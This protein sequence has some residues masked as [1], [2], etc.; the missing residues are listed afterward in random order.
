MNYGKNYYNNDKETETFGKQE[1]IDVNKDIGKDEN[2]N[3]CPMKNNCD[4]KEDLGISRSVL[5]GSYENLDITD[6]KDKEVLKA[7]IQE[8]INEGY[9]PIFLKY[10]NQYTYYY[11]KLTSTLKSLLYAHLEYIGETNNGG[12]YSLYYKESKIDET[13]PIED[14]KLSYFAT[15]NVIA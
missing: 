9:V 8:K 1:N 13:I 4:D 11:I 6:D 7:L 14:L 3:D 2:R 5:L 12:N 10:K 15:I